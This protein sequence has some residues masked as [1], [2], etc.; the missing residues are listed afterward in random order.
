MK[1]KKRTPV[2]RYIENLPEPQKSTL[3]RIKLILTN[4]I[5]EGI[6]CISYGIPAIKLNGIVIGGFASAKTHCSYYPF[7]GS[8]LKTL[9]NR[10]QSFEQT[11][12]ALHF[13]HDKP[14]S[15]NIV[16]ALIT[17]RLAE[18]RTKPRSEEAN[19]IGAYILEQ[20]PRY[21]KICRLLT[22]E[23]NSTLPKAHSKLYHR[24]PVWFIG[25]NAV[26]GFRVTAKKGVNLLFWNGQ[27]LGES[28]LKAVGKF[29]AAQIQ[30]QEVSEINVKNLRRWI[31]K[32]SKDIW[33]F[34]SLRK[35]I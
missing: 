9:K 34:A 32:A 8:T 6:E 20:K 19:A 22:K 2:D 28:E 35:K 1:K 18:I 30:F 4:V 10:L 12:S 27:S 17:A 7:S 26:V 29:W 21:L 24:F 31:N 5:P 25:E 13:P 23:I 33:D 11:K 16:K 3:T 15:K 14:L